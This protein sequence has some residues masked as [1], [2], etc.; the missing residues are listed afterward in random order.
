[1]DQ[2]RGAILGPPQLQIN[3]VNPKGTS[4]RG[5]RRAIQGPWLELQSVQSLNQAMKRGP[6]PSPSWL[7][8]DEDGLWRAAGCFRDSDHSLIGFGVWETLQ[9][10]R[11]ES[12]QKR[13]ARDRNEIHSADAPWPECKSR[14]AV[15]ES[16][17]PT[18]GSLGLKRVETAQD[19]VT[20]SSSPRI[21]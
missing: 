5:T 17:N 15:G 1:V 21:P 11:Y 16:R 19:H 8:I 7:N 6:D 14:V 3:L 2:K 12:I 20:T 9:R 18:R 10:R 4:F 13:A